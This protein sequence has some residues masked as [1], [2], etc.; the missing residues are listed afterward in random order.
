[1]AATGL[2]VE[3]VEEVR[4]INEREV[5]NNVDG[6]GALL[7]EALKGAAHGLHSRAPR[8]LSRILHPRLAR[9]EGDDEAE[10]A[11]KLGRAYDVTA[12]AV[13]GRD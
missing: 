10:A 12:K 9:T 13:D 6:A 2:V 11:V 1:M 7:S 5:E 4:A 8:L 3:E